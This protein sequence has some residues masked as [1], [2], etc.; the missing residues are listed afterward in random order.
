M[1]LLYII[2]NNKM[3][4]TATQIPIRIIVEHME[5]YLY[6]WCLYEY[7][8]MKE[9]LAETTCNLIITNAKTIY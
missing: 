1:I 4:S 9:Y 3:H 7:I 2:L 5:E 8:Q 6:K